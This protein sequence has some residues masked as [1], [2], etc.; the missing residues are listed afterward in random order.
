MSAPD[1]WWSGADSFSISYRKR[2]NS[3]FFFR[4][5]IFGKSANDSTISVNHKKLFHIMMVI[6]FVKK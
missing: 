5:F 1:L 3:M 6:D 4:V 2:A